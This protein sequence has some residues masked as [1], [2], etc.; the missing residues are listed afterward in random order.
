MRRADYVCC[1]A[2]TIDLKIQ[3][4]LIYED[5]HQSVVECYILKLSIQ[6]KNVCTL[7]ETSSKHEILYLKQMV[8]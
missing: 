5:M 7:G 4:S 6:R 2:N 8:K 1:Q 3:L